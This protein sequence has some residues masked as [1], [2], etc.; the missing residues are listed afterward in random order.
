[1]LGCE[2]RGGKDRGSE[3]LSRCPSSHPKRG[4]GV[5]ASACFPIVSI[6]QCLPNRHILHWGEE[7]L[8]IGVL[9]S[10]G[11]KLAVAMCQGSLPACAGSTTRPHR[12]MELADSSG[13]LCASAWVAAQ[14]LFQAVCWAFQVKH[15]V[16]LH[17]WL[18]EG[19]GAVCRP[20]W[21]LLR[22]GRSTLLCG[23]LPFQ[24]CLSRTCPDALARPQPCFMV[25]SINRARTVYPEIHSTEIEQMRE[26]PAPAWEKHLQFEM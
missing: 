1:M 6:L 2:S 11:N 16:Q 9:S 17:P 19:P 10:P 26:F 14:F 8:P 12:L 20:C 3:P 24:L 5:W 7:E 21:G 13:S 25:L 23:T 4:Q 22:E 15:T 18:A